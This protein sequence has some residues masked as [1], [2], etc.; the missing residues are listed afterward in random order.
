MRDSIPCLLVLLLAAGF[1]LGHETDQFTLPKRYTFVD[2]GRLLS[3]AHTRVFEQVV[4]KTNRK[5]DRALQ[6]RNP[7]RRR[8]RLTQLHDPGTIADGVQAA[9]GPAL[10]DMDGLERCLRHPS[11][12]EL[13]PGRRL[14]YN[15]R[16]WIYAG[17]HLPF[18]PRRY[19]LK[20]RSSTIKVYGVYLG[21]DK[22]G[23]FHDLGHI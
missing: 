3:L 9:F 23:H 22:I 19:S 18:D 2:L 21:V 17:A 15:I 16:G 14:S 11:A 8:N 10:F 5:I 13:F 20:L 6:I 7:G 1:A 4:E 12:A